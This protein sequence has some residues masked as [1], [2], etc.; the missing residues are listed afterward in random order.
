MFKNK[1]E[2]YSEKTIRLESELKV[3]NETVQRTFMFCHIHRYECQT[4]HFLV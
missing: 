4:G 3:T 2:L 1:I